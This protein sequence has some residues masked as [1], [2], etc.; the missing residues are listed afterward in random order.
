M[1][2]KARREPPLTGAG[3]AFGAAALFGA[4]APG[5]KLLL[6]GCSPLML[7][8]LLYLG[9]AIFLLALK[10]AVARRS[11]S[12]REAPLRSTDYPAL[13]LITISGGVAG[14][15]LML[16]GL[17]HVS[18]LAGSLLLNLEAPFTLWLAVSF[19]GEYLSARTL[20]GAVAVVAGAIV[21]GLAPGG[22]RANFAGAGAIAAACLCWAIDNN[23]SQRLSVR[24]PASIAHVKALGAGATTATIAVVLGVPLPKSSATAAAL[25][26]GAMSY[27]LSLYLAIHALRRLGAAREAAYFATAPFI[28]AIIS[29]VLFR[30]PPGA[31]DWTA[32]ILMG[33][34]AVL[35]LGEHHDH[36]HAHDEL[37]HEHLHSHDIHHQ[38]AH[39]P[40]WPPGEP[41]SHPHHHDR[42]VHSHPHTSDIHHRH[43]HRSWNS[44]Q[45]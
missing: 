24:D 17:K 30:T 42:L 5:A 3:F 22:F 23:L 40:L 6:A 13:I 25:A 10:V 2:E 14:P 29:I 36:L 19:F 9:A 38:H 27:G 43:L 39:S 31:N 4:S 26:L 41:H 28:G 33:T 11:T 8:A 15:I 7:S 16:Y 44:G 18:A 1:T 12:R 37:T 34:G 21:L 35:L 45:S 32:A 20:F